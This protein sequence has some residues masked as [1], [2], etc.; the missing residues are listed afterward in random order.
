MAHQLSDGAIEEIFW[1][2]ATG[3]QSGHQAQASPANP[4]PHPFIRFAAYRQRSVENLD[5]VCEGR[6]VMAS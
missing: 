6:S 1:K 5:K 3:A 2:G 4:G